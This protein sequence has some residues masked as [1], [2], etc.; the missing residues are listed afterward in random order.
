MR[1]GIARLS[2]TK[3]DTERG[4][5]GSRQARRIHRVVDEEHYCID[6][7]TQISDLAGSLQDVAVRLLEENLCYRVGAIAARA[8]GDVAEETTREASQAIDRLIR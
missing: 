8:G 1:P 4:S 3:R 6:S 7:L 2:P 5:G